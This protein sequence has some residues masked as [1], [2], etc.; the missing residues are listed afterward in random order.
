MG[1]SMGGLVLASTLLRFGVEARGL[2]F[3][4]AP[5][6]APRD[7]SPVL[8]MIAPVLS[9]LLPKLPV[10]ELDA[11]AI[12]RIPEEVAEYEQ[13]PYVFH[14]KYPARTANELVQS[15]RAVETQL[16]AVTLPFIALYGT[17]D[18][19]V[20][21]DC[22]EW[23]LENAQSADKRLIRFEGGYHELFN[24][25]EADRFFDELIGWMDARR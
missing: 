4:S 16:D 24:D 8:Q 2:V 17:A 14:D 15:I 21:F 5:L 12:S 6:K 13:D 1:H 7:Q 18:R 9:A 20:P 10:L 3:S 23:L 25:L 19:L 11:K 22:A